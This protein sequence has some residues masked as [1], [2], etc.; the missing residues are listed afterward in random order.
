VFLIFSFLILFGNYFIN[1][2][3]AK[4][5]LYDKE[6]NEIDSLKN[7]DL[8]FLE[9][10][11]KDNNN[12]DYYNNGVII[13]GKIEFAQFIESNY[14]HDENTPCTLKPISIGVALLV[15]PIGNDQTCNTFSDL[16]LR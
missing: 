7:F 9:N 6:N 16:I 2:V 5:T 1:H 8:L 3:D 15:I 12:I 4:L 13:R 14:N 10:S 11:D